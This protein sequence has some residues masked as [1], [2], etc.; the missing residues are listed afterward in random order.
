MRHFLFIGLMIFGLSNISAQDKKSEAANLAQANN[1]LA[2]MTA[3]NFH[4]YYIPK[5]TEAPD[6]MYLNTAWIRF[7]KPLANGKL[8]L[9][10]SAPL[11]TTP[12]APLPSGGWDMKSGLGDINAFLSYSFK[13]DA[14]QTIGIGPLVSIPTETETGLG[15]GKWQA[16]FAN[17]A[18]FAKSPVI[19]YGYLLTWQASFA[20]DDDRDD[21]SLMAM[22]PFAMWQLGKG[23]YVRSAAIW[24]FDLKNDNYH[25]PF[26]VGL[27]K[28]VKVNN[29]VFNIF[30]EPQ[31]SVLHSGT[32]PQLQL[33]AGINLQ[34]VN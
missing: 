9:R 20:G 27:G 8:L 34:L 25:I 7:A 13:S 31:Y 32:Q 22:Q 15:A 30:I 1:P 2:K 26:S 12:D 19:Q 28:I 29:T 21:T 18:F 24:A 11:V 3:I 33:F 4:N 14:T 5:L 23:T 17:V 16:G 10:V 6:D